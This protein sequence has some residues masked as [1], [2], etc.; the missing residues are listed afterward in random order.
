MG[1]VRSGGATLRRLQRAELESFF[2]QPG[3]ICRE[4]AWG[5]FAGNVTVV[6]LGPHSVFSRALSIFSLVVGACVVLG[7]TTSRLLF[8]LGLYQRVYTAYVS[9]FGP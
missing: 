6:F 7:V 2:G 1:A 9:L 4:H 8:A 5:T 3:R